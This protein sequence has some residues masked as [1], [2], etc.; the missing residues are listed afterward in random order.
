M[1]RHDGRHRARQQPEPAQ[2]VTSTGTHRAAG[3]RRG[4]AAWPIACVVLAGLLVAGWFGWNWADGVLESR[5]VAEVESCQAGDTTVRVAVDPALVD[6]VSTAADRWNRE[7]T[8]VREHC[9]HVDVQ[10]V[11]SAEV[12]AVLS[13]TA[14]PADIGG[15]PTAWLPDSAER[16]DA[17]AQQHPE[18]IGSSGLTIASGPDGEHRYLAVAGPDTRDAQQHA[19]Q[20]FQKFLLRP[21]QQQAFR[22]AG[23]TPANG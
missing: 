14:D 16:I 19:A 22:A 20:S 13:G 23:L 18:L 15:Y 1:G 11:P 12:E 10:A 6:P 2:S 5:A 7:G 17:L 21:A 4:V 8:V 9:V 3:R